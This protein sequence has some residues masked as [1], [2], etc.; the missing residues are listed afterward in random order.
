LEFV[1][2]HNTNVELSMDRMQREKTESKRTQEQ[3]RRPRIVAGWPH[4]APKNSRI[5]PKIP[6]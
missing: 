2:F 3:A 1:M 5:F 6:L 4:F